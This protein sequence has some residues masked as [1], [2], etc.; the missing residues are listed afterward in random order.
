MR[1]QTQ[2]RPVAM[3]AAVLVVLAVFAG[4]Y[5][6]PDVER[7][8]SGRAQDSVGL[9]VAVP[10]AEAALQPSP[11]SRRWSQFRPTRTA[12]HDAVVVGVTA[13][14]VAGQ[15]WRRLFTPLPEL[16]ASLRPHIG[17]PRRGPPLLLA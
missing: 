4:A 9:T 13:T 14:V 3:V 17:A 2:L 10:S 6:R 15:A 1:R 5:T 16:P 8:R 11:E 7:Q 12:D